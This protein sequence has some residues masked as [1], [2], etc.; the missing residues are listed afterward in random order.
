MNK[1]KSLKINDKLYVNTMTIKVQPQVEEQVSKSVEASNQF[2]IFDRSGSMHGYLGDVIN[3][4]IKYVESLPE[5]STVSLGY[6]SGT[7]QYSLSVPYVLKKELNG[8]ITTLKTYSEAL[9]LTNFIEILEKVNSVA[10]T[11]NDKSSLFFFT[12]GC[13]NS[14]GS[15]DDVINVL[16]EWTNYAG[17]T[18]FVG[19]GYIDRDTM[20]KMAQV[21]EGTFVHL[22]KF[23]NFTNT[24]NDFK[25][26]VSDLA[27][28]VEVDFDIKGDNVVPIS[29]SGRSVVEYGVVDKKIKFKL[30]KKSFRGLYFVTDYLVEGADVI[31][32][33]ES[34][35][36]ERGIRALALT[37][38]QRNNVEMSLELLNKIGDKYL[39]DKLYN[40]I[41]PDEFASSET[42]IR[43]SIYSPTDRFIDGVSKG[44]YLPDPNT[45]C[46]LDAINILSNDKNVK[47][48]VIDKDFNYNRIGSKS[49]RQDGPKI[50]YTESKVSFNKIVM[51][52]TRLNLSISTSIKGY[53]DLLSEDYKLNPPTNDDIERLNIPNK[54]NITSFKTYSIITDGKLNVENLVLSDLSNETYDQL[55][56]YLV[57]REEG[58]VFILKLSTL[59][60]INKTYS[61]HTS[62]KTL[63]ENVW[64]EKILKDKM[65]TLRYMNKVASKTEKE[66]ELSFTEEQVNY[67]WE[68]CYIKDGKYQPPMKS[69]AGDDEYDA[70]EFEI[71]IKGFSD[72]TASSVIKKIEENKLILEGSVKGKIKN[73]TNREKLIRESYEYYL[74]LMDSS[75]KIEAELSR[76]NKELNIV[77]Q[78]IQS[79]KFAVILV[80]K[81]KLDEFES[82]ENQN[83]ELECESI[84]NE[85]MNITFEFSINK[86]QVKI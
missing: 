77:R 40:S 12:D 55:K 4:S 85:K 43:K 18:M 25:E 29:I 75:E 82:R 70:Y 16:R 50:N 47:L 72:A 9:C 73:V 58:D 45:F 59:P 44:N 8:A 3:S 68:H 63:A 81:G 20:T 17:I 39:I 56:P 51:N 53:I 10:K 36:I 26:S 32:S 30:T 6:F 2:L 23:S 84:T 79:S 27:L 31:E 64:Q 74:P 37:Y 1:I 62:A 41:S 48:H 22:D 83:I 61:K 67:L 49:I 5:G 52:K 15:V 76:L 14:G 21:T 54:Y 34:V 60:L 38:S 7:N 69:L 65:S 33:V 86:I 57:H 66:S 78:F 19:Y 35:N 11:R 46:V 28:S 24:L 13:H 42:L 71:K 80:N